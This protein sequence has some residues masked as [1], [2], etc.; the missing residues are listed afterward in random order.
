MMWAVMSLARLA[1]FKT[2]LR[3]FP[4]IRERLLQIPRLTTVTAANTSFGTDMAHTP[5]GTK[6]ELTA[7]VLSCYIAKA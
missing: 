7:S 3:F 1:D 5:S 4:A 2:T 6:Q